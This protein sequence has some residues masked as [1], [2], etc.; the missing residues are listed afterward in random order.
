MV[1]GLEELLGCKD[2]KKGLLEAWLPC[3]GGLML[4]NFPP[5]EYMLL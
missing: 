1:S 4:I 5:L 3:L 2:Q